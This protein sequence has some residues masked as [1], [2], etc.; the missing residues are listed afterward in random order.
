MKKEAQNQEIHSN[1]NGHVYRRVKFNNLKLINLHMFMLEELT[2]FLDINGI[3]HSFSA[4]YHL[5][6]NGEAMFFYRP[7]RRP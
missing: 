2:A 3:Q 7:S 5:A 1:G 6:K 4:P